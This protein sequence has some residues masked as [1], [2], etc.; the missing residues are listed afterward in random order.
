MRN[1]R[2]ALFAL[3][4]ATCLCAEPMH[5]ADAPQAP[6]APFAANPSVE[7]EDPARPGSPIGYP[8]SVSRQNAGYQWTEQAARSGRMGVRLDSTE[9][10]RTLTFQDLDLAPDALYRFSVWYRTRQQDPQ[11]RILWLRAPKYAKYPTSREWTKAT[12]LLKGSDTD[13]VTLATLPFENGRA[14][15]VEDAQGERRLVNGVPLIVDLDDFELRK[16]TSQDFRGNLF[17]NPGFE[18]GDLFPPGWYAVYSAGQ[19]G[20]FLDDRDKHSGDKSLRVEVAE[21][22]S[23]QALTSNRL[24]LEADQVYHLSFWMKAKER[25]TEVNIRLHAGESSDY[26]FEETIEAEQDWT[27]H[28]LFF[29]TLPVSNRQSPGRTFYATVR[30]RIPGQGNVA[31]LDDMALVNFDEE[32]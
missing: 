24:P 7:R 29:E 18:H 19:R 1:T 21:D 10:G 14:K 22:K 8:G 9:G 30:F 16:L 11:P 25:F 28:D 6:A 5:S 4:V 13:R 17:Q 15:Y 12:I 31:W 26:F 27:R 20:I 32:L 23:T 2:N 3:I